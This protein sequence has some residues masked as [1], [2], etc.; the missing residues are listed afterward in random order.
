MA[1]PYTQKEH[2]QIA[3][4]LQGWILEAL[5]RHKKNGAWVFHGGTCLN[6]AYRSGRFSEDLDFMIDPSLDTLALMDAVL[7]DVSI[8]A[9]QAF[10]GDTVVDLK[11]RFGD[12]NPRM[13]NLRLSTPQANSKVVVKVEFWQ[14]LNLSS[15]AKATG[16]LPDFQTTVRDVYLGT[17]A[18]AMEV[19]HIDQIF[20]D[21]WLALTRRTALKNRDVWDASWLLD[22]KNFQ[23]SDPVMIVDEMEKLSVHYEA[24]NVADWS[25][26]AHERLAQLREPGY[27][28][29]FQKEMQLWLPDN[30]AGQPEKFFKDRGALVADKLAAIIEVLDLRVPTNGFT[31]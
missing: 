20:I 8:Q 31:P 21:K 22:V 11:P 29:L 25:A 9:R 15:Y 18:T 16:M 5:A 14:T 24:M 10:K 30:Y 27:A 19:G 26:R 13:F 12:K 23:D 2:Q 6:K 4:I 7:K 17:T 3:M 1:T 28:K